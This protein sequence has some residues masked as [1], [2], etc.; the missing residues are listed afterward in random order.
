MS[1]V[2]KRCEHKNSEDAKFCLNCGAM[3]EVEAEDG[4]DPLI[5]KILLGR[6]RVNRVL[7]EGGMGKVYMAEQKM[8]TAVRKVA[9]K[10]LHRELSGD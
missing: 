3:L 7:G 10:T 2:C 4:G 5:G 9:I 6:Y 1:R 8:G